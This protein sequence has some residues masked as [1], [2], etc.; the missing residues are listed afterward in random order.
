M[1]QQGALIADVLG[2]E[3]AKTFGVP[4]GI[5]DVIINGLQWLADVTNSEKLEDAAEFGRIG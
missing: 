3:E 2:K 1:Q 4:I 5:F